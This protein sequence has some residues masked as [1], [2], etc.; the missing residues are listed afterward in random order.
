MLS[1]PPSMGR[2]RKNYTVHQS[3]L[4]EEE[5]EDYILKE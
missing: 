5:L 2:C 4:I 3:E 1:L